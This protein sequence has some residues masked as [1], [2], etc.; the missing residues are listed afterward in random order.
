MKDDLLNVIIVDDEELA[1]DELKELL[2]DFPFINIVG[3]CDDAESAIAIINKTKPNLVFLDIQMPGKSGFDIVEQIN[4]SIEIVFVTAYNQYAIRAFEVNAL[5]Y[6]MK[7]IYPARLRQT[8]E[9]IVKKSG[10]VSHP[11]KKLNIDDYI[12][13]KLRNK[14]KFVKVEN[15]LCITSAKEYTEIITTDRLKGLIYKSMVEWE[16]RLP[17]KN[18]VRIHRSTIVNL[19]FVEEIISLPNNTHQVYLTGIKEPV[20]MSRRYASRLKSILK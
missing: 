4:S 15:I 12:Y 5:D 11:D 17:S 8:I 13:L 2:K 3:E 10:E 9:R 19:Q 18:F 7:P 16:N 14:T 20:D 6:L 1:R